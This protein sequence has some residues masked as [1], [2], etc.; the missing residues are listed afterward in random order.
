MTEMAPASS[1]AQVHT[2]VDGVVAG[3]QVVQPAAVLAVTEPV[4]DA[5]APPEPGFQ[6]NNPILISG[7]DI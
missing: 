1:A 3:G 4:L 5:G 2:V 7:Q 6:E